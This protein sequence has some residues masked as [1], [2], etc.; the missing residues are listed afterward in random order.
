M[1]YIINENTR[2]I[3]TDGRY[4]EYRELAE[5]KIGMGTHT[6]IIEFIK[7]QNKVLSWAYFSN[8]RNTIEIELVP[9]GWEGERK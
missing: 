9:Q 8:I 4:K 5:F 7:E 3:F 6:K 1:S 2:I